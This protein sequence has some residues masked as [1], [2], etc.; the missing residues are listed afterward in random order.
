MFVDVTCSHR[1]FCPAQH[2]SGAL[3]AMTTAFHSA[4]IPPARLP[5]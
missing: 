3:P 5:F 2:R 1:I 4:P